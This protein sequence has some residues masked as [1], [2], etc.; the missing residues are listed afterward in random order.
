MFTLQTFLHRL[1]NEEVPVALLVQV[2]ESGLVAHPVAVVGSRPQRH[3]LLLEPVD[4][5]LLH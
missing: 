3:Q 4:V 5:P 1:E 2:Q